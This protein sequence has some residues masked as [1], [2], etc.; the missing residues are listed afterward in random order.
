MRNGAPL[1]VDHPESDRFD[2]IVY[3]ERVERRWMAGSSFFSRTTDVMDFDESVLDEVIQVA[4]SYADA[5]ADDVAEVTLFRNGENLGSYEKGPM[6]QWEGGQDDAEALFG[7]RAFIGG[8]AH[9]WID[10]LVEEA[11]IY[12]AALSD[13]QIRELSLEP[14]AIFQVTDANVDAATGELTITWTSRTGK[15]YT[16][17]TSLDLKQWIEVTDGFPSEGELTTMTLPEAPLDS[18]QFYV[19]VM[20]E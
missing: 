12:N 9:G 2:A 19:R 18:P 5:D 3:A 13:A 20:E 4:I 6:V 16:V 11:R 15:T 10:A 14:P 8:T 17:E 7:P 1:A